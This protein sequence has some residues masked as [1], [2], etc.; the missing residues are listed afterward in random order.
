M[1]LDYTTSC[2]LWFIKTW[3]VFI[4]FLKQDITDLISR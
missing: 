1:E 3:I 4:T 2:K